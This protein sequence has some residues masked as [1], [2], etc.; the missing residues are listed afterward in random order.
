MID[1]LKYSIELAIESLEQTI[2][3]NE[4]DAITL[5]RIEY[6]IVIFKKILNI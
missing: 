4:F 1:Y 3:D 2:N 6:A 5:D